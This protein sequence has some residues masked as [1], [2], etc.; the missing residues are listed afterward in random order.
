MRHEATP[1]NAELIEKV[2]FD[3]DQ[4]NTLLAKNL[5]IWDKKNKDSI[6]LVCAA[7]DNQF[8]LKN[9]AKYLGVASGNLRGA[10]A[11]VLESLLGCKGGVV[12][13]YAMMND[14]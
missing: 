9:L 14:V 5:F 4:A 7:V 13:L 12:N 8:D 3:G 10:D 1:T 11:P 2:K 6:W